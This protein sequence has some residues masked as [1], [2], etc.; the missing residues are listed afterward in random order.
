MEAVHRPRR[1]HGRIAGGG[2]LLAS[3]RQNEYN[4][5]RRELT[6]GTCMDQ[7]S[8]LLRRRIEYLEQRLYEFQE[9][10]YALQ[11]RV[12]ELEARPVAISLEPEEGARQVADVRPGVKPV[13]TL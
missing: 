12:A 5:G 1:G 4:R 3:G 8:E 7:E 13:R 10:I 2:A 11:T 6:E 9:Q